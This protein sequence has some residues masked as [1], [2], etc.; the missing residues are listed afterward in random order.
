M[1]PSG[2]PVMS[3]IERGVI[4]EAWRILQRTIGELAALTSPLQYRPDFSRFSD[5]EARAY[6]QTL[7]FSE[8]DLEQI[9]KARDRGS[10]FRDL[11]DLRRLRNVDRGHAEYNNFLIDNRIFIG[12][13]TWD[14][15]M[16]AGR[17]LHGILIE[18]RISREHREAS[19]QMNAGKRVQALANKGMADLAETLRKAVGSG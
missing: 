19:M 4:H 7:S 3:E 17:E 11:D 14:A 2:R 13:P 9:M 1:T 18:L 16:D 6:L 5:D 15:M 8:R 10:E 12:A